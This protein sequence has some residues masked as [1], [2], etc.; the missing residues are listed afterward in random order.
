MSKTKGN[1]KIN[2]MN[3]EDLVRAISKCEANGDKGSMHYFRLV[4]R[5]KKTK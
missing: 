1:K 5:L 3:K 4:N 2:Y